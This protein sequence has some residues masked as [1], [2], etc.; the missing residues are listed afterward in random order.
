V[1][2]REQPSNHIDTLVGDL[3]ASAARRSLAVGDV[4]VEQGAEADEVYVVLAGRLEAVHRSALGDVVV[5]SIE[6]GQVVGEVTVIAGG[7]R[8]ATLRVTEPVGGRRGLGGGTRP[9]RPQ[10]GGG[11]DVAAHRRRRTRPDAGDH[12]PHHLAPP[13]CR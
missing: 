8:T 10:P 5:G 11:D 1:G 2:E 3:G 4:L 9:H 7:R 12:A 6:A 13:G